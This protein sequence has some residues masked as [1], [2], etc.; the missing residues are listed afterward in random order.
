MIEK[1]QLYIN[2]NLVIENRMLARGMGNYYYSEDNNV[3]KEKRNF[4]T[5]L[6]ENTVNINDFIKQKEDYNNFQSLLSFFHQLVQ[7][8]IQDQ[9][10]FH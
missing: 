10:V 8:I 7:Y 9:D 6:M 3:N 4:K 5:T 2:E 1:L